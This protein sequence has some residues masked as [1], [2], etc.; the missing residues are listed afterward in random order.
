MAAAVAR[1]CRHRH[2]VRQGREPSTVDGRR[3][4]ATEIACRLRRA[5]ARLGRGRR[6]TAG[7]PPRADIL[8]ALAD[9]A[10]RARIDGGRRSPARRR[11]C[12]PVD[13]DGPAAPA[14]HPLARRAQRGARPWRRRRA[15]RSGGAS[16]SRATACTPTTSAPSSPGCGATSPAASRA[17]VTVLQSHSYPG[18]P[19]DRRARHR[20]LVG[21]ALRAA[22]RCR[23]PRAGRPRC[24]RAWGSTAACS[25][26]SGRPRRR[27]AGHRGRRARDGPARGRCRSSVGG[28]DFAASTLAAGV[29]EPGEACLMLGTAGNLIMPL[30]GRPAST[31]G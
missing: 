7:G 3:V 1:R 12:S 16:E 18:A 24:A 31:R 30:D 13:D 8:R 10:G 28:A 20:P 6:A 9:A 15:P 5:R 22:L 23:G 14:R 17:T 19:A 26:R 21:R 11:P 2:V 25:P 29:T 27:R 4:A